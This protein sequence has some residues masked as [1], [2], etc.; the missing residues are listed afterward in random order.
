MVSSR[1]VFGPQVHLVNQ[2]LDF[3]R[4]MESKY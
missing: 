2:K 4:L 1:E 3:E